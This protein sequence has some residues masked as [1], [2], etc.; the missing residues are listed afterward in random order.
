MSSSNKVSKVTRIRKN[1]VS[2]SAEIASLSPNEYQDLFPVE[3]KILSNG[4]SNLVQEGPSAAEA[5]MVFNDRQPYP[6]NENESDLQRRWEEVLQ[7]SE[8]QYR[9][10]SEASPALVWSTRPDGSLIFTNQHFVEFTGLTLEKANQVGWNSIYHAEDAPKLVAGWAEAATVGKN[11]QAEFRFRRHDGEYRWF[12]GNTV[13]LKNGNGDITRWLWVAIDIHDRI[14]AETELRVTARRLQAI[15]ASP[16]IGIVIGDEHGALYQVNDYYLNLLGYTREEFEQRKVRWDEIT[17]PEYLP[18]DAQAIREL[19]ERGVC[20]PYEKEYICKDG[21]RVWVLIND[22]LLPE[23]RNLIVGFVLDITER[24][25]AEQEALERDIKIQLQH[26]LLEQREQDRLKVAQDLHDGPMQEILG[27]VYS[28]KEI[29]RDTNGSAATER[30]QVVIQSLQDQLAEMRWYASELR[31]PVLIQFGINKAI[32]GHIDNWRHKH[33]EIKVSFRCEQVEQMVPDHLLIPL[34]RIYQEIINNIVKHASATE[35]SVLLEKD[36]SGMTRLTI[37]DN[38]SGFKLPKDWL[39]LA[40]RG[41]LGL[42]GMRERAEAIGG[43]LTIASAPGS[44]TTIQVCIPREWKI[45]EE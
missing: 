15:I 39:S 2:L 43:T 10:L 37:R 8:N 18:R 5:G 4:I 38:G 28:L 23:E 31:P 13:P 12:L 27:A 11:Y 40:R 6:P 14:Q 19:K 7:E 26:R 17:P 25:H 36:I 16:L 22:A 45:P 33:P 20:T 30:I 44:G 42:V 29:V 9:T 34:F 35:V 21:S 3:N 24:K 1:L 41:H 32:Q